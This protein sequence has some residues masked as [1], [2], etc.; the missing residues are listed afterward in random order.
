MLL[1]ILAQK[2][3]SG[4]IVVRDDKYYFLYFGLDWYL[5]STLNP[6][7]VTR[8]ST[9]CMMNDLVRNE[10][11]CLLSCYNGVNYSWVQPEVGISKPTA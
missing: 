11:L 6:N 9:T 3:K 5:H 1:I 7:V 10:G 4:V 2:N 8:N